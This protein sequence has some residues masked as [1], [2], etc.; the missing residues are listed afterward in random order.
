M[1]STV[2]AIVADNLN[3]H[4]MVSLRSDDIQDFTIDVHVSVQ[5]AIG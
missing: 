3:V 2:S 1:D 5:P 4:L